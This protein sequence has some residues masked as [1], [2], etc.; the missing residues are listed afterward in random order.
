MANNMARKE[1][2][3]NIQPHIVYEEQG[4]VPR[5]LLNIE[6]QIMLISLATSL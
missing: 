3:L 2:V 4:R 6:E 5:Q 1:N